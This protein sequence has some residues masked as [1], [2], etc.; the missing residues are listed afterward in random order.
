MIS[1]HE[2]NK[3]LRQF[4]SVGVCAGGGKKSTIIAKPVFSSSP[5]VL[6]HINNQLHKN[7]CIHFVHFV[8]LI[9]TDLV[10]YTSISLK[11]FENSNV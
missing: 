8:P 5:M 7:S 6:G 4:L 2:Y 11:M 10:L 9:Q 3:N 1:W